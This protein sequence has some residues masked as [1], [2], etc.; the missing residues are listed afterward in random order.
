MPHRHAY[1]EPVAHVDAAW[2]RMDTPTNL[3][4]ITSL[5]V[6]DGRLD[7]AA[8]EQLIEKRLLPHERFRQ[9]IVEHRL[10]VPEWELDPH[11]DLHRHL[12]RVALPRPGDDR[13][14]ADLLGDLMSTPLDHARPLWQLHLV[15]G[16]GS[17]SALIA[18]LH[19][20][21]GDGVALL[22]LM[23]G[24]TE[25]GEGVSLQEVGLMPSKP[26]RVVD[27][28]RQVASQ[29]LT[30]GRLLI[31]PS[32]SPSLLKGA[33]G[34]Q[35]RAAWSGPVPV[36]TVKS[37]A[38]A[39]GAKVNDVLVASVTGALRAY[40]EARGGYR[41]ELTMR[42]MVPVFLRNVGGDHELGNHFGLVFLDLPLREPDPLER[43][44]LVKLR[45][46]VIKAAPDAMVSLGV[47]DAMGVASTEIERIGVD[48][49]TRKAS[50]MITNVPGPPAEL[51]LA[52]HA[53][54]NIMVWAPVSGHIGLG[55]SLL[56]YNG[57]VR[58][59]VA[60]DTRRVPDP[61]ALVAAFERDIELLHARTS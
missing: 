46:D 6:F 16:F 4:Q 55:I 20:C 34:V 35:K 60:A 36:V 9:R 5:L 10:G 28:A 33:L 41:D 3:M 52:D 50:V 17:G 27:A 58:M 54:R 40:M 29:A 48:L 39:L 26:A 23:L 2:L 61:E 1:R 7:P 11:F 14:L 31:L 32:D 21:I 38:T 45:M 49:F 57:E 25:E 13:A 19:H 30:L 8:L 24:L 56:S 12:H 51:H 59:G 18:R 47:L 22:G 37:I 44:R 15:E 43:V 53:L 42:A